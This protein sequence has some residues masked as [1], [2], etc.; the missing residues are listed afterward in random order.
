[1]AIE[2]TEVFEFLAGLPPFDRLTEVELSRVVKQLISLYVNQTNQIN[3]MPPAN[4]ALYVVRSAVFDQLDTEGGVVARLEHG[5]TLGQA[6]ALGA[7]AT[8]PT[9]QVRTDG[10]VYRLP[11]AAL[12]KAMQTNAEFAAWFTATPAE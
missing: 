2:H 12:R 1:M 4:P 3:V 9:V 5:D 11:S 6:F 8:L 10:L 7:E